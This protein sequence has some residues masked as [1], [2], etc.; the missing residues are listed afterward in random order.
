MN[1]P[2]PQ[3]KRIPPRRIVSL[4]P[5]LTETL[6]AL[7]GDQLLVGRTR[8]CISPR[9]SVQGIEEVGGIVDPDLQRIAVL[10][11]DLVLADWEENRKEDIHF[12]QK[13]GIPVFLSKC[14]SVS[15]VAPLLR[16]LGMRLC[17]PGR[18]ERLA[19][20]LEKTLEWV[21][22]SCCGLPPLRTLCLIWKNPYMAPGGETYL[23][24]LLSCCGFEN[25]FSSKKRG[26]WKVSGEELWHT[27]PEVI[28]LPSEPYPF[29]EEEAAELRSLLPRSSAV[30]QKRIFLVPGEL[31]CWHGVR[32]R[33]GLLY[34]IR[35]FR[36][37]KE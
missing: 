10:K 36:R 12:L 6:F 35:L 7:G 22:R 5:S 14:S 19:G 26:Y 13:K 8:F 32:T 33:T 25:I 3:G 28:L 34:L 21:K 16:A 15:H 11:P 37:L 18:G 1:A 29:G 30:L 20:M 23:S 27:D 4:V 2:S 9:G 17:V 24:D 31:L